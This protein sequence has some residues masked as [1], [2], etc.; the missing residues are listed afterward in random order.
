MEITIIEYDPSYALQTVKMWRESKEQAIEQK[1]M[2][3]F[4]DHVFF[5]NNILLKSNKVNLAIETSGEQVVGIL[6]CNE[7][8]VNQLY[9]HTQ[10]QG[11][12]I[13]N[14]LLNLA[15]QQSEGRLFLYTFEVNKKAQ[16]FYE[17]NGFR[18]VGRGNDN[19]EQLE[20]IKYEWTKP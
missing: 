12:G 3:S 10:Y 13:G 7:N 8:W 9:V 18:I 1:A 6:A 15:K 19:E 14:R 17:R 5:L 11:R 4:E 20:D 16:K 2:H